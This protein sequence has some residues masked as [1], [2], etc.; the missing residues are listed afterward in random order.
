MEEP[1]RLFAIIIPHSQQN[2]KE[3]GFESQAREWNKL[4]SVAHLPLFE[5]ELNECQKSYFL[6]LNLTF[7]GQ[8]Y[9]LR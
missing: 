1:Y 5:D 4:L 6:F 7:S 3:T 2:S 9:S 8:A